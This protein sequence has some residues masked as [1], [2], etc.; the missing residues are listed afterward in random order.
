[1]IIGKVFTASSKISCPVH[2]VTF[3]Y[4]FN[5]ASIFSNL[6]LEVL[7]GLL[8]GSGGKKWYTIG[9]RGWWR[10]GGI[11][12]KGCG[13]RERWIRR[14]GR[15]RRRRKARKRIMGKEG[16]GEKKEELKP[17][18]EK[19]KEEEEKEE[20]KKGRK[21]EDDCEEEEEQRNRGR[22]KWRRRG[23]RREKRRGRRKDLCVLYLIS[24]HTLSFFLKTE[25]SHTIKIQHHQFPM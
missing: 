14:K 2:G 12:G 4:H 17:E 20:E 3:S 5:I 8:S 1:M 25:I 15:R 13:R 22:R 24:S 11:R 9:R 7:L 6:S 23:W 18:E 21:K 16:L 19:E 10:V